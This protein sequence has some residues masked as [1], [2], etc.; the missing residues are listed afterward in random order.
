M[1]TKILS[2]VLLL[3]ASGTA[4]AS[5]VPIGQVPE[6]GAGLGA[7]QTLVTFQATGTESGCVGVTGTGAADPGECPAG[8]AGGDEQAI[9]N[10]Y[11]AAD[12]G[13]MDFTNLQLIFNAS[14]PGNAAGQ[15]ITLDSLALVL[16]SST[17]TQLAAYY[18]AAPYFIPDVLPGTGNAGFGFEL[19]AAQL[20][21]ANDVLENNPGLIIGAAATASGAAGG[22][23]TVSLRINEDGGGG[24]SEIPE[25]GTYAL[26][27]SALAGMAAWRKYQT[28]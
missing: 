25:P 9:N 16:Y 8:I 3:S 24:P 28:R 26:A 22:L 23:E 4:F 18:L 21:L 5:L 11:A 10:V 17:G 20:L 7:V 2:A 12:V 14:E 27:I 15:S 6:S 19:D 1:N 13:L